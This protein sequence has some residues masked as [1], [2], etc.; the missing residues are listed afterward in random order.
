[1]FPS[2]RRLAPALA[3]ATTAAT[4]SA[5]AE[6]A[7]ADP[8]DMNPTANNGDVSK[9]CT[10][11]GLF[12]K[13][14]VR[15]EL[16][17]PAGTTLMMRYRAEGAQ[18]YTCKALANGTSGYAWA[19]KAPD[20]RLSDEQC[21]QVGTHFAG[22]SWKFTGD[23]STVVGMKLAETP[24]L[25]AGAIPWLLIR[26]T[27]TGGPGV[28]SNVSYIQRVDTLGGLAPTLGCDAA[29]AGKEVSVPYTALYYFYNDTPSTAPKY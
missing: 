10:P 26:T 18:I 16:E 3:I 6:S 13:P 14:T 24:P 28:M 20:A 5:C 27:S 12:Q 25:E 7:D 22:P 29:S 9:S 17:P 4:V 21:K 11:L 15:P 8:G 1:M 19:L 2:L 23:G